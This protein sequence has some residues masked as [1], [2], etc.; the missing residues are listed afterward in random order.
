LKG[1]L[2]TQ[3]IARKFAFQLQNARTGLFR[4]HRNFDVQLTVRKGAF[5][6]AVAPFS[7]DLLAILLKNGLDNPFS[8]LR[9]HDTMPFPGH[10][11]AGLP[12]ERHCCERQQPA[13]P[14]HRLKPSSF[15]YVLAFREAVQFRELGQRVDCPLASERQPSPAYFYRASDASSCHFTRRCRSKRQFNKLGFESRLLGRIL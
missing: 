15:S 2:P 8:I 13:P 14:I 9:L 3:R 11:R 10:T 12:T 7:G 5:N 6:I 1:P 4:I